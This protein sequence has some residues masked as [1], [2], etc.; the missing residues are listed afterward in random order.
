VDGAVH[1]A[2]I[3]MPLLIGTPL[4]A[5]CFG[6]LAAAGSRAGTRE[7]RD[8]AVL[9]FS[10]I[11]V[12]LVSFNAMAVALI[13]VGGMAFVG[14]LKAML[15]LMAAFAVAGTAFGLIRGLRSGRAMNTDS[16]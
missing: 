6:M 10:A 2:S 3:A 9:L 1:P 5:G 12:L 4:L 15:L 8:T 14:L 16:A 13:T 7:K 11:A